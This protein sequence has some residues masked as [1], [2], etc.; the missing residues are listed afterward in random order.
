MECSRLNYRKFI[1]SDKYGFVTFAN[2]LDA[3]NAIE[4]GNDDPYFPKYDL[5][6]GGR[7]IFCQTSYSDLGKLIYNFIALN[8]FCALIIQKIYIPLLK[9]YRDTIIICSQ[10]K[11][12]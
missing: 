9:D 6:F 12:W 1:F 5:S 10:L 2:K 3:Y 7:R 4:H 8:I 11:G